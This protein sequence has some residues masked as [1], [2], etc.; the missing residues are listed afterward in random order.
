MRTDCEWHNTTDH[1][2][3]LNCPECGRFSADSWDTGWFGTQNGM[4]QRWGGEC[5]EHGIWSDSAQ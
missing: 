5:S 3:P 1:C 4:D 2:K